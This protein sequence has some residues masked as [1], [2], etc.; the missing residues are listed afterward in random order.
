MVRVIFVIVRITVISGYRFLDWHGVIAAISC[1]YSHIHAAK[2]GIEEQR[3]R[4]RKLFI[5]RRP[6]S[7]SRLL[8]R[9]G[10][11]HHQWKPLKA[12]R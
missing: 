8:W 7:W 3:E 11:I 1:R 4:T 12:D 9:G 2:F 6:Y 10:H 5:I